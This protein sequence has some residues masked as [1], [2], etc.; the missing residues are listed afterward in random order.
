LFA[1]L[2]LR[3]FFK[4][5]YRG[6]I[7]Y[8]AEWK[9][10]CDILDFHEKLPNFTTPQKASKKLLADPLMRKLLRQTLEQAYHPHRKLEIDG[11]DRACVLR[12][13][14][15]AADSTGFESGHCSKYFTRRKQRKSK[16]ERL[17]GA[18]RADDS[19]RVSR[20]FRGPCAEAPG[21]PGLRVR[22]ALP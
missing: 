4:L 1:V 20:S 18:V 21:L 6:T 3:K 10:L 5:D 13:D 19:R 22:R 15:A 17:C 9:E 12:I 7:A 11:D 2:V 16:G 8:L 14:Q